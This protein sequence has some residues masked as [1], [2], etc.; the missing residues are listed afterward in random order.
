MSKP[1]LIFDPMLAH[2]KRASVGDQKAARALVEGISPKLFAVS[3]RLLRNSSEA[4]EVVQETLLRLW[5]I[6]PNWRAGNARIDTWAYRVISN[7]CFDKL[8]RHGRYL[9]D[10]FDE[11][12]EIKSEIADPETY[13]QRDEIRNRVDLALESLPTRQKLAIIYT[14]FENLGAKDT[15]SILDTSIE[16]VESLLSRAKRNLKQYFED[17]DEQILDQL[18]ESEAV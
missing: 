18:I 10:A 2:L 12:L 17:Q 13:L 4:E 5:R 14:Y 6:A 1:P 8:R 3:Y 15:A 11:N 7:L 16:A 9:N